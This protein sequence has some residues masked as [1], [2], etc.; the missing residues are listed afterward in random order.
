M[1]RISLGVCFAVAALALSGCGHVHDNVVVDQPAAKMQRPASV[2]IAPIEVS[3]KE[4]NADAQRIDADLKTDM[5]SKLK[6][7]LASKNI[8][9]SHHARDTIVTHI[10]VVYGNRALRFWVGFGAGSGSVTVDVALKNPQGRTIYA[11]ESK[12][13]LS[14]GLDMAK[15]SKDA[16]AHAVE[17]FGEKL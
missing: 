13:D 1:K 10:H 2:N 16:I 3:S 6:E 8:A 15:V 9:V 17:E 14:I 5:E 12:A 7:M 11:T 4:Q